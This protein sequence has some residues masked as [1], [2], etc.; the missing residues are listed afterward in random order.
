MSPLHHFEV[1]AFAYPRY[2]SQISCP[3][4]DIIPLRLTLT[5]EDRGALDLLAVSHVI[6]AQLHTIMAFGEQATT[7]RP[8]SLRNRTAFHRSDLAAKAHWQHDG[9]PRELPPDDEHR[10]TRWRVKLNGNFERE[11]NMELLIDSPFPVT[12]LS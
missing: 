12:C 1:P 7:V 3:V 9:H 8:L 2:Y 11:T 10:R 6:N 5:S 4:D